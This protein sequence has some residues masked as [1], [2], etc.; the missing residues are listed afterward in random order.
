MNGNHLEQKM[1]EAGDE[2][3]Q[4]LEALRKYVNFSLTW[5]GL[6][7]NYDAV[8]N[9]DNDSEEVLSE[10]RGSIIINDKGFKIYYDGNVVFGVNEQGVLDINAP[11]ITGYE[12]STFG[13][14]ESLTVPYSSQNNPEYYMYS[15]VM[16]LS[17]AGLS[18]KLVNGVRVDS[19]S[20][21]AHSEMDDTNVNF[22]I[23]QSTGKMYTNQ[24][25]LYNS[26]IS[27]GTIGNTVIT[28]KNSD[29]TI[30]KKMRLTADGTGIELYN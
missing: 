20:M 12:P 29:G 6:R 5:E 13:G 8:D 15:K 21:S 10:P 28:L 2:F 7:I 14:W 1:E 3:L 23:Q 9:T 18:S 30:T 26:V 24:A 22:A 4:Q 27:G 11:R 19:T 16:E 25:T 17:P